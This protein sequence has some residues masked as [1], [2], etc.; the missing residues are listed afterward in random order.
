MLLSNW[1][2]AQRALYRKLELP[3][4][5]I[6]LLEEVGFV[7]NLHDEKWD[8]MFETLMEYKTEVSSTMVISYCF[9]YSLRFPNEL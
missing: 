3:E 5:R 7:W 9:F 4:K 1:V 8:I 2:I 6:A